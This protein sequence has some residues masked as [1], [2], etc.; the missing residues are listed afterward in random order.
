MDEKY[1]LD[2]K[3]AVR[4]LI[5]GYVEITDFELSIIDTVPFQRLKD[6][7]QLTCQHVYPDARHTRFEHSLGV[8]HLINQAIGFINKNGYISNPPDLTNSQKNIFDSNMQFNM[9]L[10]ALLHDVG[11]CPF[12]HMIETQ[13][14]EIDIKNNLS[15]RIG[16]KI[17]SE[18]FKNYIKTKEPKEI[19]AKHEQ[20]SCIMVLEHYYDH[21]IKINSEFA[22]KCN[23]NIDLEFI[24]RS[25]LGIK[26]EVTT[27]KDYVK[28]RIKNIAIELLNSKIFDMD[29]LDYVMR[30]SFYTGINTP[31][32]DVI[33]LF[34]NM[35]ISERYNLAFNSKAVP[36]LQNIIET[37]DNLYMYVYNHHAVV[38]SDFI[39]TYIFRRMKLNAEKKK[40]ENPGDKLKVGKGIVPANYFFSINT[41]VKKL[42]SDSNII[43]SLMHQYR[44][45]LEDNQSNSTNISDIDRATSLVKQL[46]NRKFLKPFW[47]NLFEFNS[48]MDKHFANDVIRK[49]LGEFICKN[50]KNEHDLNCSEFCSQ[51]AKHVIF[52]TQQLEK[53]KLLASSL[54]D[55]EF[56]IVKRKNN[57]FSRDTI[58]NLEIYIRKNSVS[59]IPSDIQR[60]TENYYVKYLT[61][62][63]PQKDF[64]SVFDENGFY[65]YVKPYEDKELFENTNNNPSE[66]QKYYEV[67]ENIFAFVAKEFINRGEQWFVYT[68][69][70]KDTEESK[71]NIQKE[72]EDICQKYFEINNF[73]RSKNNG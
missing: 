34:Q 61:S 47:K 54:C 18:N 38:Y 6:I 51:L 55:G 33:R 41:I 1:F 10:A 40:K 21:F 72:L 60:C 3:K 30:D 53:E 27:R 17:F 15:N 63:L 13:L 25:I 11:H 22:E 49:K 19:G 56:F 4:D 37:R 29:K 65:I 26:Y 43:Y 52:I 69:Q 42:Y 64:S 66:K 14:N 2:T 12:S 45:S 71:A 35:Y 46:F 9:R 70:G 39:Y 36:V 67:I 31:K 44:L 23:L 5:H 8:L 58:E 57:F 48:F 28:Y 16:K 73:K 24:F 50:A 59:C 7:R 32:I 62:I 20:L 68:F